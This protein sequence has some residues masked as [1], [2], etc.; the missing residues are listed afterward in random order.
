MHLCWGI[1]TL[2]PRTRDEHYHPTA[3]TKIDELL[4][5]NSQIK[6][7]PGSIFHALISSSLA[8]MEKKIYAL[9]S[10]S[11]WMPGIL[12]AR[13][14]GYGMIALMPPKHL[15]FLM[16]QVSCIEK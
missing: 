16:I 11:E 13:N 3:K 14:A 9:K 4:N 15:I 6:D 1:L 10:Q 8:S 12:F 2:F 7:F 5:E